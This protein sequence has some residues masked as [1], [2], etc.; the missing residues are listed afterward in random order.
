V[1]LRASRR[2]EK[3]R[4]IDIDIPRELAKDHRQR[5]LDF[6]CGFLVMIILERSLAP[7]LVHQ[8]RSAVFPVERPCWPSLP[9]I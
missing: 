6:A 2:A 5:A 8:Q 3:L 4:F 1:A 9:A 7:V